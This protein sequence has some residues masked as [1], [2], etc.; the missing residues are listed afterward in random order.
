V[1][2]QD[3]IWRISPALGFAACV[4]RTQ[5][6]SVWCFLAILNPKWIKQIKL[7]GPYSKSSV[8]VN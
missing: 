1:R 2:T 4:S 7:S 8:W 5:F 3:T 6:Q